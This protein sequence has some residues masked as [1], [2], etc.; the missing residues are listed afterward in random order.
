MSFKTKQKKSVGSTWVIK[1]NN[2]RY[3]YLAR[4]YSEQKCLNHLKTCV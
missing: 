4:G 2:A 1:G 3:A